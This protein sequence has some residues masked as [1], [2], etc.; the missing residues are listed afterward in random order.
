MVDGDTLIAMP[1]GNTSEVRI[2]LS[3]ID[4]PERTQPFFTKAK[5]VLEQLTLDKTVTVKEEGL[6]IFNRVLAT[7]FAGNLCVNKYLVSD[8]YKICTS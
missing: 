3:G 6:D 2:R 4:A 1:S 8:F 7:I 5:I